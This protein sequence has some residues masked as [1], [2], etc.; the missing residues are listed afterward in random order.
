MKQRAI[1]N[2]REI[3]F[4]HELF[5]VGDKID[6]TEMGLK[7]LY[8]VT[9]EVLGTGVTCAA[10][11]QTRG[12]VCWDKEKS[13]SICDN[14][15]HLS[16]IYPQWFWDHFDT[17]LITKGALW[18]NVPDIFTYNNHDSLNYPPFP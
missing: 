10:V 14:L 17:K 9:G 7:S 16:Q 15:G 6:V 11:F 2:W 4:N 8:P 12:T 5:T 1:Q 18:V 13:S 3:F